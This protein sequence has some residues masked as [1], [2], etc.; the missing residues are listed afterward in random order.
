MFDAPFLTV[1]EIAKILRL[2]TLTIYEYIRSGR[3]SAV[4]FGRYYRIAKN[5]FYL[6]LKNQKF[7]P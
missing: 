1:S 7:K 4:R 6:F 2:N 3:L 5:D